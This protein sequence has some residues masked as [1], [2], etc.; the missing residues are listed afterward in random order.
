MNIDYIV[1]ILYIC[2]VFLIAWLSGKEKREAST[3]EE[4]YL[5]GKKITFYESICSIIATE[6][7]ALTFLGIPPLPDCV[8]LPG[9]LP[10]ILV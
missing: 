4:Q 7:S 5:A 10:S 9:S 6:V 8:S 2:L 3:P 1:I